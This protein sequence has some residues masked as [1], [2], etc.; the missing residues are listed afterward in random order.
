MAYKHYT[1]CREFGSEPF[2]CGPVAPL[3][4]KGAMWG[5]GFGAIG[6]GGGFVGSVIVVIAV[7]AAANPWFWPVV[8]GIAIAAFAIGFWEGAAD[9]WLYRRL[10]CINKD[11]C[12]MGRV[13][14]E[15]KAA[16]PIW[17][18]L[19]DNDE[20][21]NLRLTPHRP[22]D[23]LLVPEDK[24]S[25]FTDGGQ[26]QRLLTNALAA[27]GVPWDNREHLHLEAEG[28]Y[29]E[30][31][32]DVAK[33]TGPLTGVAA[34]LAVAAGIACAALLIFCL[35]AALLVLLAVLIFLSTLAIAA[36]LTD[37]GDVDETNVGDIP[38]GPIRVDDTV[39]A[40]GDHVYDAGHC[41]G[42]N[43]LHPLKFLM[44][45]PIDDC[46]E[47]NPHAIG[48][49]ANSR[50]SLG[51]IRDGLKDDSFRTG[52]QDRIDDWC[53][54]IRAAGDRTGAAGAALTDRWTVHPT[55][56]GCEEPE[57][58]DAPDVPR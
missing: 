29:W 42:W 18:G 23:H 21:F 46:P 34:G 37:E 44:R 8:A 49:L 54:Q 13:S 53:A 15:P 47:W 41:T 57:K 52:V 58:P 32:R 7:G 31:V 16:D 3:A 20:V 9:H 36:L 11:V 35:I 48:I 27:H 22:D 51:Q 30:T 10:I 14:S 56:D 5:L 2:M 45:V 40:V 55:V 39:V 17:D 19:F 28:D 38:L 50:W 25:T 43:E 24:N 33:V 6:F 4:A 12:A 1:R 26:G